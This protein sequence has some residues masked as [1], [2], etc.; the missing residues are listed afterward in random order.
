MPTIA[1]KV[2][3][4]WEQ[5]VTFWLNLRSVPWKEIHG[6]YYNW[7][8]NTWPGKSKVL[9]Y[10]YCCY[11]AKWSCCQIVF[12]FLKENMCVPIDL[13]CFQSSGSGQCLAETHNSSRCWEYVTVTVHPEMGHLY[14][15]SCPGLGNIAEE[16]TECKSGD[17][18]NGY[19]VLLSRHG[20]ESKFTDSYQPCLSA[21]D[22]VTQNPSMNGEPLLWWKLKESHFSLGVWLLVDCPHSGEWFTPMGT[23]ATLI[24]VS[25]R[26]R[27]SPNRD[28]LEEGPESWT[29]EMEVS[30]IKIHIYVHET[31]E[32]LRKYDKTVTKYPIHNNKTI[33]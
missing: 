15:I 27:W 8:N 30:I 32:E 23:W 25:M 14:Q 18:G 1:I 7:G 12:L 9:E 26:E 4:L 10:T 19:E 3:L 24:G 21:E 17:E 2:S 6:W 31:H 33:C 20:M 16:G 11:F 22:Q 13:C 5:L 28:V 29:E